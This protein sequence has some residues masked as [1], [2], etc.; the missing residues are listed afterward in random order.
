MRYDT[1]HKQRTHQKLIEEASAAIRLSGPDNI[2]VASLMAKVGLTH[3]GF[4]AHFKSKDELVAETITYML[5]DRI[6][7]FEKSLEGPDLTEALS[8]YID[9]YLSPMHRDARD[10]GCALTALNGD[11]AR[12]SDDTKARFELG[13]ERTLN[14]L[15]DALSKLQILNPKELASSVLTEMVGALAIS[16][17]LSNLELSS[18]LLDNTRASVKKRIGLGI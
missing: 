9:A 3:G 16:R 6:I 1:E 5:E 4:Y 8:S 14:I 13:I 2:S 15:S 17:T 7:A 11:V 18:W 10:K 12:M